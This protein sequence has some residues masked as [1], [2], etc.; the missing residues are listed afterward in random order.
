[1]SSLRLLFVGDSYTEGSGRNAACNYPEVVAL[2]A[3]N[4]LRTTVEVLNAGVAGYGP[5]EEARLLR[6]LVADGVSFDAV[7]VNLFLEND[8]TDNL[9]GTERRIVFGMI[10]RF[11]R[12]S[13]LSYLH[14]LNLR[15]AR[16]SR[17]TVKLSLPGHSDRGS[18]AREEG[19][20]RPE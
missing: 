7:V 9:P 17:T 5:V 16:L 2:S 6:L 3:G 14:P 1:S 18:A 12:S 19:A 11:P 13:W 20:C 4:R 10:E 15:I 8:F